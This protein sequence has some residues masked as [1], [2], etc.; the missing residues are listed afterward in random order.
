MGGRYQDWAKVTPM[1]NK[2]IQ[3]LLNCPFHVLVTGRSKVDYSMDRD[4]KNRTRV[5]KQGTKVVTREGFDYE[6]TLA[7]QIEH[8]THLASIDKDRTNLFNEGIPFLIDEKVGELVKK[9]NEKGEV[10]TQEWYDK[11]MGR[12]KELSNGDPHARSFILEKLKDV[13][14]KHSKNDET[15]WE[16]VY[17]RATEISKEEV[18]QAING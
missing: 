5:Q 2:F 4:D 9:W 13:D 3:T 10:L 15:F 18:E 16:S 17:Q 7:F 8:K 12:L 14:F 1:H 11:T 6:M